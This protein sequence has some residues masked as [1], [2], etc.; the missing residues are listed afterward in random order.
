VKRWACAVAL[1]LLL[2]PAAGAAD[3]T[4]GATDT[5]PAAATAGGSTTGATDPL[6]ANGGSVEEPFAPSPENGRLTKAVATAKFLAHPKVAHWLDRYPPNPQTDATFDKA[7]QRWTVMVWSGRAGEIALGKVEDSDGRVSEAYTGPQVAWGMAR[8]RVG[9]F[10][11]KILNAWWMWTGLSIIFFLGLVD[12][13]RILSWHT[14]DLLALLSFGFSLLFFNRGHIFMSA[15]LGALPLAYLVVR[16]SWIGFRGRGAN[17][18]L[19]WP[20]WL[21]AALAVFLGG[22]RIGLNLET[23]RG[24]IDVGLAGVIGADRI[25]D[26]HAPYGHMPDTTG[27]ACGPADSDGAI[28][29]HIQTNGLCESANARGDTYGPTA[30][31]V[32]VPA[33]LTLG[34]TGKWDSLPAA[35]ATSIA[36]DLLAVLGLF[37]V[38]RRF[39]GT[40]LGTAL[41][42]GWVAFPFTAYALNS[43]SN[44]TI[45][46]AILVWGFW[47]STS[48]P[49]RGATIALA[50]WTKFAALLLA[51]LWLTYPNGLRPRTAAKFAIGFAVAT[52]AVFSILLF[53]PSLTTA[54]HTFVSRTLGYQLDRESPFSPW[55]WGQYHASGIPNLHVIQVILQVSVLALAGVVAA[56]PLRKGP[57]ELAALSAAV[58]VGFELTL[59]HWSYLYI[60]WFLPFVLL[61]LLLPRREQDA[62]REPAPEPDSEPANSVAL[63]EPQ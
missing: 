10:G 45:M 44:D 24:V 52:L 56:I 46:P 28:R 32:Y 23:P 27:P 55:D 62:M 60:P 2:A 13:R 19:S 18:A 53:E 26:H 8:G 30:Y 9:S 21:L 39:G 41:A 25:L 17:P 57:L 12:R 1:A 63:P 34:W 6:G 59:T 35:H 49:A 40:P 50:G 14:A 48:A 36:F 58:L 54:V 29:D 43:N 5:S 20:V 61:T 51:P 4:G 15:S 31:L 16:T 11:G 3:T 42:F 37:L 38:G 7:T 22:L 47:L 33:V